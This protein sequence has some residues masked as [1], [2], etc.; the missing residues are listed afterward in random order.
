MTVLPLEQPESLENRRGPGTESSAPR[1]APGRSL[2]V[3]QRL[4]TTASALPLIGIVVTIAAGALGMISVDQMLDTA[5]ALGEEPGMAVFGAMLWCSPMQSLVKRT[6]VP[7]RKVLGILFGGYAVSNFAMFVIE[8][9][10]TASLSAP[11]LIAGTAA[12]VMTIPLLLTSG[13]WAQRRMGMRNWR[14]LHKL[15]YVI[16]LALVLHVALVGE[17]GVSGALVIGA[18]LARIPPVAT[19]IANLGEQMRESTIFDRVK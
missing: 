18:L 2:S 15:T 4:V 16:A 5:L 8:R 7:V 17:I 10:L 11:F 6:Q 14:T 1:R 13:R 19:A 12:M 3:A 9:G